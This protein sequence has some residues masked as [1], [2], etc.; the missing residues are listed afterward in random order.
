M[1]EAK[2]YVWPLIGTFVV[3]LWIAVMILARGGF[4]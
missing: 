2:Y 3:W 1:I 4:S